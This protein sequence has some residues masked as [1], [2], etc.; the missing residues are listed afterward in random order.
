MTAIPAAPK[1]ALVVIDVQNEYFT[2][3]LPIEHPPTSQSL[4]NIVRAMEAAQA[5]GVPVV[6]VQHSAPEASPVFARGSASWQLHEAVAG[7]PR[8]LHLEKRLASVFSAEGFADWL[9]QQGIDT[10]SLVGYMTHN[11]DA[12]TAY[13][14]AHRGLQVEFLGDATGALPYANEAGRVSAEEVHRVFSVVL[15]TG[16]AAVASTSDWI[17]AVQGGKPLAKSNILVSNRAARG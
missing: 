6:L 1:R 9:K 15:H 14:A 4:P 7:K 10:L 5:A 3:S 16:F 11:C 12:A 17:A 2:G 8:A 13:E